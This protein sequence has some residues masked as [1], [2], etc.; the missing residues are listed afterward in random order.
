MNENNAEHGRV[1]CPF[2]AELILQEAKICR[3]CRSD[4]TGKAGSNIPEKPISIGRA[5]VLN[6]VCP[7]LAAWKLGHKIRGAVILVMVLACMGVY[8]NQV[9]PVINK[10]VDIAVRT[11]NTRKLNNLTKE[12]ESN[13]WADWAMYIYAYSFVD[14]FFIL[15]SRK[16][17]SGGGENGQ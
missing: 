10:S 17:E 3:F 12:L 6:I 5:L 2:C 9:I 16:T 7:G 1:K 13:P 11:G 14:I 15:K 8:A 4:L